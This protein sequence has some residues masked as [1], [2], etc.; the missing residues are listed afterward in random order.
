MNP[1]MKVFIEQSEFLF[2]LVK[3][4]TLLVAWYALAN[5]AKTHC[6]FVRTACLAGSGAYLFVWISWFLAAR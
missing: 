2:A 3:G 1:L 5:Y 4:L 6:K